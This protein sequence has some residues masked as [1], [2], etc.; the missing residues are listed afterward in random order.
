MEIIITMSRM[1]L[2]K[3]VFFD[4]S[5]GARHAVP[6]DT[7]L[8]KCS[9]VSRSVFELKGHGM[10]CP[11]EQCG[12]PTNNV[13]DLRT[14][15]WSKENGWHAASLSSGVD[16]RQRL[17]LISQFAKIKRAYLSAIQPCPE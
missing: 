3:G 4:F 7:T 16:H 14:M 12:G 8:M 15:S 2:N 11:Y 1:S 6:R 13:V 5:V 10:P 17:L 9:V